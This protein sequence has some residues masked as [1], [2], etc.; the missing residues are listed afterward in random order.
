MP[1]TSTAANRPR[2]DRDWRTRAYD[3]LLGRTVDS[4]SGILLVILNGLALAVCLLALLFWTLGAA[5]AAGTT[6]PEVDL[7]INRTLWSLGV[8]GGAFSWV[9]LQAS[10]FR[11]WPWAIQL[12]AGVAVLAA[13]LLY[14]FAPP[15]IHS[16]R[17][18]G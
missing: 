5:M 8:A 12:L 17:R 9:M 4:N 13:V 7:W 16:P 3:A 15:G 2:G 1:S 6:A 14:I 10:I 11:R 18:D